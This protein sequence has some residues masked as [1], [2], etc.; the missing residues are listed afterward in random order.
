MPPEPQPEG[1][2]NFFTRKIGGIPGFV[3]LG[4]AA[5]VAYFLFFRGKGSTTGASSSGGGGTPST[6]DITIQPGT[7]TVQIQ[8]AAVPPGAPSP[9][10]TPNPQPRFVPHPRRKTT[11]VTYT[12]Y[13]VK[14]GETLAELAKR[15]GVSVTQLAHANV[16]VAG[17]APG[18]KVGQ[19][20]GTGA[21]LKTGQVLRIP[22]YKTS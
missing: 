22:H 20:L 12:N 9:T 3:W 11:S 14:T 5:V 19:T 13:T 6:G 15:F 18:G 1:G 16:Y 10:G 4:G 21:G 17:E 8:G 2:G 7:T